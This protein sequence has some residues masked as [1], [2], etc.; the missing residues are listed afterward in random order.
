[1]VTLPSNSVK[2]HR[3][4][5]HLSVLGVRQ[6]LGVRVCVYHEGKI[7]LLSTTLH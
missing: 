1:M 5:S 2:A 4:R 3:L 7:N 6:P